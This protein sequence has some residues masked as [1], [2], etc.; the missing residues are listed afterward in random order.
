M[1]EEFEWKPRMRRVARNSTQNEQDD[2]ARV[3]IARVNVIS[4]KYA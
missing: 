1:R 2:D 3:L 4:R